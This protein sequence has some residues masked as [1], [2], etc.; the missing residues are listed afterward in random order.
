LAEQ[1]FGRDY[2]EQKR[3]VGRNP[4]KAERARSVNVYE[5]VR[6]ALRGL[7][8]RDAQ[9]RRA[10]AAIVDKHEPSE[11]LPLEQA[12]REAILVATAA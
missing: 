8:F 1:T 4:G 11:D 2:V 6:I 10:V 5:K 9:A 3:L 7:G 12:L